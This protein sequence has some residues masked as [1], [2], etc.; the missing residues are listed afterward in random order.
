MEQKIVADAD[1]MR[2]CTFLSD[3]RGNGSPRLPSCYP[4]FMKSALPAHRL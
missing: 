2:L 4:T 3:G 1:K